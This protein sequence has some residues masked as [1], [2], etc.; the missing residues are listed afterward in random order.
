MRKY[1]CTEFCSFVQN[2]TVQKC[3]ALCSVYLMYAKL[4]EMQTSGMYLATV[5]KVDFIIS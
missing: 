1:F 5:Q 3:A 2:T 4:M